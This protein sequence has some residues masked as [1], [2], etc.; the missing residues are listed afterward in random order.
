MNVAKLN[1]NQFNML[2]L[3]NKLPIMAQQIKQNNLFEI[4]QQKI[5]PDYK[6]K[7]KSNS[8]VN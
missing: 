8:E 5:I 2:D 6:K 7:K 3:R 1:V 4:R